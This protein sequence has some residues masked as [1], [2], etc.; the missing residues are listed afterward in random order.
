MT[1]NTQVAQMRITRDLH[2][3]EGALDEALIRQA[4]LFATMVSARRESGAAPFMGQDAL[5]RLAKSQ[6][7]MLT[8][9]GRR[10]RP[11]PSQRDCG[12]DDGG[13]DGCPPVNASLDEPAVVT[14]VAA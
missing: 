1:M 7:S 4:R 6:Q 5:L 11:R 3:A 9:G 12:G 10:P 13:N 8:A 14:G 2:D